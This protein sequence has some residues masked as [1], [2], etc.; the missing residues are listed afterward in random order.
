MSDK[1]VVTDQITIEQMDTKDLWANYVRAA[2]K[3][4]ELNVHTGGKPC[5]ERYI[6][7]E[8]SKKSLEVFFK[9]VEAEL[10]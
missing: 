10:W 2:Q 3:V 6:Y 1:T 7:E 9:R 4:K 5:F 8:A